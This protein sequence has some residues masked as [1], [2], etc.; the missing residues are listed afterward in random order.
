MR[1]PLAP[2]Y[3]EHRWDRVTFTIVV[4]VGL[5]L[6]FVTPGAIYRGWFALAAFLASATFVIVYSRRAWR[7]TYAGRATMLAMCVTTAYSGNAALILWWPASEYGYPGWEN[8]VEVIYLG[9]AI[10]ALY[11]LRALTRA[12]RPPDPTV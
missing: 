4:V 1:N 3:D 7:T 10:A 8:V 6:A 5:V 12:E 11:K 9:L 2:R